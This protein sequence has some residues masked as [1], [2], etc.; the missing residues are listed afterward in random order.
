MTKMRDPKTLTLPRAVKTGGYVYV[1]RF[2]T[3]LVKVGSTISPQNRVAQYR[4]NIGAFGI[5][6][7]SLWISTPHRRYLDSE[8]KLIGLARS[9]AVQ[10]LQA[11]YFEGVNPER[12]VTKFLAWDGISPGP[13]RPYSRAD[14]DSALLADLDEI[15][16]QEDLIPD[17][18]ELAALAALRRLR[19]REGAA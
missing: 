8:A 15:T 7:E 14:L 2:S 17:D 9:M 12:L 6:I 11:E 16:S 4:N 5:S 3:G 10:V 1:I 13:R 19:L 18:E